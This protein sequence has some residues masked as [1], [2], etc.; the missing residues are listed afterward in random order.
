MHCVHRNAS[1]PPW[2]DDVMVVTN[3][4]VHEIDIARFVLDDEIAATTLFVRPERGARDRQFMVLEMHGGVVVDV[5]V[6]VNARYGYD[7]RAEVSCEAG[8]IGLRPQA[9][10]EMRAMLHD[11]IA[12]AEDWRLHFAAAYHN[13]LQ[14]FAGF[15]RTGVA[16]GASAY[17]GYA[18]TATASACLEAL[19]SGSRTP[20]VLDARASLYA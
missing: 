14:A 7:V 2:F 6:F 18:A 15:V 9:P 4:A 10:V 1:A 3:S 5:E 11:G 8:S 13:Q 12:L 20:V 17:D 16:V 19:Q